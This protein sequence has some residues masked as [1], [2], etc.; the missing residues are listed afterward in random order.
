MS[1]TNALLFA[2]VALLGLGLVWVASRP[3]GLNEAQV[4]ALLDARAPAATDVAAVTGI[5]ADVLDKQKAEAPPQSVAQLDAATL[6]PMIEDYLLANPR[7]LQRVS[8]AL[9]SE[10]R[11]AQAA[12]RKGAIASLQSVIYDDPDHIVLGNP[13]GDVTLVEL[14]DYNCGYCRSALPDMATLLAE[15]PNLRII[16]KEFPILSQ[17][18]VDAAKVGVVV[19][20]D[21]SID[22]WK[23]HEKLFT[24]RGQVTK[25]TALEAAR[26]LGL[27]PIE[28][29]LVMESSE[30]NSVIAKSFQ[31][32]DGLNVSGTPTYI[33]GDEV[34]PG[35]IGLEGL[36]QRIANMRKCG[37]TTCPA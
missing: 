37:S 29:G 32:A 5:I 30:V 18:S 9:E 23:F 31:I 8:E 33:I 27:N 15:D 3:T 2:V 36:R 34:I 12:E 25:D 11:T 16:L 1:R 6:N 21:K 19:A 10:I 13:D 24:S 17:G 26:D 7:I 20:R 14:F 22:Y 35:A 28:V 4:Q